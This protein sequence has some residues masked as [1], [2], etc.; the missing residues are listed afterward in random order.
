MKT[1]QLFSTELS[2]EKKS[3]LLDK[4]AESLACEAKSPHQ[5]TLTQRHKKEALVSMEDVNRNEETFNGLSRLGSR[6]PN[7]E[8]QCGGCRPCIAIQVPTNNEVFG[9]KYANYE[10]EGWKCKCG[11]SFFSP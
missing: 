6:P 2:K 8:H 10:P 1:V 5:N 7:C 9:V 11:T 4:K 3:R